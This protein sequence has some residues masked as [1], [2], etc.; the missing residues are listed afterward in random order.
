VISL[1]E[2][3]TKW[4]I[5]FVDGLSQDL[6][7]VEMD[8]NQEIHAV[9]ALKTQRPVPVDDAFNDTRYNR[10]HLIKYNI[11][12]VLVVPL[13]F[14][15]KPIGVLCL[16]YHSACHTFTSEEICFGSQLAVMAS[17]ALD[18]AKMFS[19]KMH[20]AQERFIIQNE[21]L[22]AMEEQG[23][24]LR[25]FALLAQVSG[26]LLRSDELEKVV[27]DLCEQVMEYLGCQ[28][29]FNYLIDNN[30]TQLHLNAYTGISK[31]DAYRIRHLEFGEA[32]CGCVARDG[33]QIIAEHINTNCDKRVDL[34]K[35]YNV[36]A[37]ACFPLIGPNGNPIGTLSFGTKTRDSFN[38]D[39]LDLIEAVADQVTVAMI[40]ISSDQ[41]LRKYHD[42]LERLV[43]ER[44]AELKKSEERLSAAICATGGGIYEIDLTNK[45]E[46]F[47]S[48]RWFEIF[49]L[50]KK[51]HP[52]SQEIKSILDTMIHPDDLVK[53]QKTYE[54]FVTGVTDTYSVEMRVKQTCGE[55]ILVQVMAYASGRDE[56]GCVLKFVGVVL[57]I[58]K[59][60]QLEEQL[61]HS[62]KMESLG[63]LAG[64]IAHDFNNMLQVIMACSYRMMKNTELGSELL[65]DIE[66]IRDAAQSS[67]RLS[68]RL[69]AFSSKQILQP[70]LLSVNSIVKNVEKLLSNSLRSDIKVST[71]LS[72]TI[73]GVNI[74]QVQLEQAIINMV[75]NAQHAI[76]GSGRIDILTSDVVLPEV[77]TYNHDA[78]PAGSYVMI[79]IADTGC[80]MDDET[81]KQ[82]FDPFFTTRQKEGGTGFGLSS[83]YAV[84]KQ[85]GGVIRVYSTPGMGTTFKIYLP[86]KERCVESEQ[87]P[88]SVS[89]I[90]NQDTTVLVVDDNPHALK[91]VVHGLQELG[92]KVFEALNSKDALSLSRNYPGEINILI[93]DIVLPW[94]SGVELAKLI[95][96]GRPSI[97]LLYMSGFQAGKLEKYYNSSEKITL[98]LK[99]FT[100]DDLQNAIVQTISNIPN[101]KSNIASTNKYSGVLKYE[102]IK[103]N[104]NQKRVLLVDDEKTSA[105]CIAY[106]IRKQGFTVEIADDGQMALLLAESLE[107][108]VIVIDIRLPDMDG[109]ELA[110]KIRTLPCCYNTTLIACSG[111]NPVEEKVGLFDEY[112]IKPLDM[113]ELMQKLSGD[114]LPV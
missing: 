100:M 47:F 2:N 111:C 59:K 54:D 67:A 75:M 86:R 76:S 85:S 12:S 102:K 39:D 74:D 53:I 19:D 37:Y 78:I 69:L 32:V 16:N 60:K 56:N 50:E 58:T 80:G 33:K 84:V 68:H 21:K 64:G 46:S 29:F 81:I 51:V 28:V 38:N 110:E 17:I 105:E 27:Q 44:T 3:E 77:H 71:Q 9:V 65:K 88:S 66:I 109:Y 91:F 15:S 43:E 87:S 48:D 52:K 79:S 112:L 22:K 57:D 35:S 70:R 11:R 25:R 92:C 98:L 55:W 31:D 93:T 14:R 90:I 73:G 24:A 20:D 114:I 4:M 42:E 5:R 1:F 89:R 97:S 18:N 82:I 40:R 61:H 8:S 6:V 26:Q 99:P 49:R 94:T 104:Q 83:A 7:G 95:R 45:S 72:T 41:Q 36:K 30:S 34:I 23:R 62:Q 113:M 10:E 108:H 101:T 13:F 103:N 96:K 107:P 106:L 63:R